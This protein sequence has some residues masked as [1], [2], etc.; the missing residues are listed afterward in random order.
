MLRPDEPF[1]FPRGREP[2]QINRLETDAVQIFRELTGGDAVKR[3]RR[4]RGIKSRAGGCSTKSGPPQ[5][6]ATRPGEARG[7]QCFLFFTPAAN[8]HTD[9]VDVESRRRRPPPQSSGLFQATGSPQDPLPAGSAAGLSAST[10]SWILST[11]S[12][13]LFCATAAWSSARSLHSCLS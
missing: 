5:G 1:H 10:S 12:L 9:E 11:L 7:P 13:S 8:C 2:E 6:R 3:E 4:G